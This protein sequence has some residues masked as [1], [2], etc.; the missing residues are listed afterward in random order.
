MKLLLKLTFAYFLINNSLYAQKKVIGLPPFESY[1]ERPMQEILPKTA[2]EKAQF[3]L[4]QSVLKIEENYDDNQAMCLRQ[5]KQLQQLINSKDS[6]LN[7]YGKM[8]AFI[9][10]ADIYIN[11]LQKVDTCIFNAKIDYYDDEYNEYPEYEAHLKEN[12]KFAEQMTNGVIVINALIDSAVYYTNAERKPY[13]DKLRVYFMENS[14][15][16]EV[17]NYE[18]ARPLNNEDM[19]P[20]YF[21]YDFE[22]YELSELKAQIEQ[23]SNV[24]GS[25]NASIQLERMLASYTESKF[26]PYTG[27]NAIGIGIT[28]MAGKELWIGGE[29]SIGGTT[30]KK[31]WQAVNSLTQEVNASFNGLKLSYMQSMN[32]EKTDFSFSLFNIS[33]F[34]FLSIEL[35]QFGKQNGPEFGDKARWF[36]RPEIGFTHGIFSLKYGYNL[37]FNKGIRSFTEKNLLTFKIS[38]P[39]IRI[40]DYR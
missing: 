24:N 20:D 12:R 16:R 8:L 27:Y 10:I 21:S 32:T 15:Y 4:I 19:E 35:L 5:I 2:V 14:G 31:H 30:N 23:I 34:A 39:L 26:N 37:M 40:S 25:Y 22:P 17:M 18:Y 7:G 6:K 1:G 29:I 13:F 38:Y 11:D 3:R 33:K 9:R 28:G 36:Y